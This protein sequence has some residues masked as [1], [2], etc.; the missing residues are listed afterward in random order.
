M[1][2]DLLLDRVNQLAEVA[3][4]AKLGLGKV[5]E[6]YEGIFLRALV[7]GHFSFR[8]DN[9]AF[10][11]EVVPWI[12]SVI[13]IHADQQ[14]YLLAKEWV[15]VEFR[16]SKKPTALLTV[17]LAIFLVQKG[18]EEAKKKPEA[19]QAIWQAI[20]ERMETLPIE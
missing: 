9:E 11:T 13:Q 10:F 15:R 19:E 1:K 12:I 4:L 17:M 18:C 2:N 8:D 16:E 20:K 14:K 6:E 7:R 5:V 3:V